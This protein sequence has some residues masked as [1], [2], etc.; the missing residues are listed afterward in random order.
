[1]S[2]VLSGICPKCKTN[3]TDWFKGKCPRC[4]CFGLPI[5]DELFTR[6]NNILKRF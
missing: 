1:M 2:I 6:K 3:Y 4:G 5:Q